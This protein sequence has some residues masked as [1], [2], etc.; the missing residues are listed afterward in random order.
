VAGVGG[1]CGGSDTT[2]LRWGLGLELEFVRV[3]LEI[4]LKLELELWKLEFGEL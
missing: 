1:E 4:E 2:G 3:E